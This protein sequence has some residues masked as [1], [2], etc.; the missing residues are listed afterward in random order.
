MKNFNTVREIDQ[1]QY[2]TEELKKLREGGVVQ[3]EGRRVT[4]LAEDIAP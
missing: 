3:I 1:E 4:I 2:L